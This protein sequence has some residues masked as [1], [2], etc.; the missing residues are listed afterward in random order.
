MQQT[1]HCYYGKTTVRVDSPH[2]LTAPSLSTTCHA[3][4]QTVNKHFLILYCTA[5]LTTALG[6]VQNCSILFEVGLCSHHKRTAP[7]FPVALLSSVA[8]ELAP[9]KIVFLCVFFFFF[10]FLP[11]FLYV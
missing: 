11:P 2:L 1:A 6:L 7:G 4:L 9:L 10:L 3:K 8:C 5:Q